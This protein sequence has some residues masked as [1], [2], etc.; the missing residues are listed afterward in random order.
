MSKHIA[1]P[2][3]QSLAN[4]IPEAHRQ[5]L[6]AMTYRMKVKLHGTNAAVQHL[7][8][9]ELVAQSRTRIIT[10]DDDNAGFAAYVMEHADFYR[11]VVPEG[12]AVFG[13]W[14]GQ[15]IQA[16]MALNK[17]DHKVFAVFGATPAVDAD[18]REWVVD[19]DALTQMLGPRVHVIPWY[20]EPFKVDFANPMAATMR[21]E[22]IIAEVEARDPWVADVFGV[23]GLGEGVVL[24]PEVGGP[25]LWWKAKGAK[26]REKQTKNVLGLLE[27]E[28]SAQEFINAF[29]TPARL[30]HA[31]EACGVS[32]ER[33]PRHLGLLIPWM[34]NDI[35]SEST[36]ELKEPG[37]EWKHVAKV[38][39]ARVREMYLGGA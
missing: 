21:M 9:G 28:M 29:V 16:G 5:G 3:I 35:Q 30:A 4:V 20:L 19:P 6:P 11:S 12:W 13:E 2:K 34:L 33:L 8:G 32:G 23:E 10:P 7:P 18:E 14:C 22:A 25:E 15:G 38:I 24:Y 17:L 26:H 39:P 31:C 36:L 1:W 27:I 37:L